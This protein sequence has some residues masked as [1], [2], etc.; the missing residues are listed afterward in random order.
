MNQCERDDH[1][2]NANTYR[3]PFQF[4]IIPSLIQQFGWLKKEEEEK[5]Y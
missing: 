2:A 1:V 4:T 5:Q 3:S